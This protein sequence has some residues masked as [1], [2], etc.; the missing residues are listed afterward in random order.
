MPLAEALWAAMSQNQVLQ[1]HPVV[2]IGS[3]SCLDPRGP[4]LPKLIA[5]LLK[6]LC[7]LLHLIDLIL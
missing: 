5:H 2:T 6:P 7:E 3:C 1:M 4:T